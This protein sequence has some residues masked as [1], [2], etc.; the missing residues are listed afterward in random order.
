MQSD[1][2]W[3]YFNA[4]KEKGEDVTFSIL[5]FQG[6]RPFKKLCFDHRQYDGIS[7]LC[8][9]AREQP[10]SGFKAPTLKSSPRPSILKRLSLLTLWWLRLWPGIGKAW[11][12]RGPVAQ[13]VSAFASLDQSAGTAAVL[14]ALDK[15][16]QRYLKASWWP[17]LWMVPV[18]LY[19]QI[20]REIPPQNN[21]AFVD[22]RLYGETQVENIT[23]QIRRDLLQG[24]YW[25]TGLSLNSALLLGATFFKFSLN[26]L[27]HFFRRTGTLT[28]L[29]T[30]TIPGLPADE[31]WAIQLTVAKLSPVGASMV[32]INGKL[33]L[34]IQFHPSLGWSEEM[35]KEF[36]SE[37]KKN[38]LGQ[39]K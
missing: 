4:L 37:W 30:W 9:M 36:M 15:T 5:C 34:G 39:S 18:A 27:H 10:P 11:R 16:S 26:F 22:V 14:A 1:V 25:G 12:N 35:A 38:L 6:Q 21:V 2:T 23:Q 20:H 31:W 3:R 28:N 17:R 33:A 24:L 8:E 13:P 32:E 7:A 19:D 29:G